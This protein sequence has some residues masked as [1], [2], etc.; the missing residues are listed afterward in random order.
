MV[1]LR[2][3]ATLLVWP[4]IVTRV[5]ETEAADEPVEIYVWCQ[6]PTSA[7][8]EQTGRQ[9]DRGL[10]ARPPQRLQRPPEFTQKYRFRL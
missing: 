4:V 10:R 2:V 8:T 1:R 3:L 6:Q 5:S 7:A 9:N